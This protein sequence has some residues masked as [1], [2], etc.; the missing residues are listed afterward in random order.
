ML[1]ARILIRIQGFLDPDPDWDFSWVQIKLNTDKK[2][3]QIIIAIYYKSRAERG[4]CYFP[5]FSKKDSSHYFTISAEMLSPT[6]VMNEGLYGS[7]EVYPSARSSLSLTCFLAVK[8]CVMGGSPWMAVTPLYSK[9]FWY[10][11]RFRFGYSL[12][13]RKKVQL[14]T[15]GIE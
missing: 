8:P 2:H 4:M 3:F 5:R 7:W 10:T 13:A 6:N 1:I 9:T 14:P 12:S 11:M 15:S